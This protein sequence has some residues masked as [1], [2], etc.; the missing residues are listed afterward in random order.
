[1]QA[2]ESAVW[3]L[4]SEVHAHAH[5]ENAGLGVLSR[6]HRAA[7]RRRFKVWSAASSVPGEGLRESFVQLCCSI[8]CS[9]CITSQL[10]D[11]VNNS[12]PRDLLAPRS[13]ALLRSA[14]NGINFQV[15]SVRSLNSDCIVLFNGTIRCKPVVWREESV[16]EVPVDFNA[17]SCTGFGAIN[18]RAHALSA[19]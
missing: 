4:R 17:T 7:V 15:C 18:R 8:W 12:P 11:S 19:R 2:E 6:V 13:V 1:M 16:H 3:P 10:S 5:A 9:A 14:K